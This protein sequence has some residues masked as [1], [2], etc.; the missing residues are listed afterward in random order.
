MLKLTITGICRHGLRT[1]RVN[2]LLW[3]RHIHVGHPPTGEH[4]QSIQGAFC[5]RVLLE[6]LSL[7]ISAL[8]R[9][10]PHLQGYYIVS[11]NIRL[12]LP[13]AH[14]SNPLVPLHSLRHYCHQLSR[15]LCLDPGGQLTLHS[16]A[17]GLD[18]MGG[19]G[20]GQM[21]QLYKLHLRQRVCQYRGRH[22]Y[23]HHA[24]L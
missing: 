2:G 14:L 11:Q 16:S 17:F 5:P 4:Y 12:P 3:L 20:T 8:L 10:H 7:M 18:A 23:G 15:G 22:S 21:H 19:L 9:F 13:A 24:N 6:K 1:Q